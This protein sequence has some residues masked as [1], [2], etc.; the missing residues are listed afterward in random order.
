M[1]TWAIQCELLADRVALGEIFLRIF[2]FYA[3]SIIPSMPNTPTDNYH[4]CNLSNRES[5][6]NTFKKQ[7][8]HIF[9]LLNDP[10]TSSKSFLHV[11]LRNKIKNLNTSVPV[12][13]FT[14][15][16]H[17]IISSTETGS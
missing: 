3:I 5:S 8:T 4:L 2:Q 1:R 6:N 9:I 15:H 7:S 14:I 11:G 16:V 12:S 13:Y 17:V 10:T